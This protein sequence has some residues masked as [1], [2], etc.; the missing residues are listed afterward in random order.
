M[1]F[2]ISQ[3]IPLILALPAHRSA[4]EGHRILGLKAF[5]MLSEYK[6]LA[7]NET[8]KAFNLAMISSVLSTVR[9]FSVERDRIAGEWKA[10]EA[11][12]TRRERLLAVIRNISPLEKGNYWSRIV[13]I[14]VTVGFTIP[15]HASEIQVMI[16][17]GVAT[18]ILV[19][20]SLEIF[21]KVLEFGL[22]NLFEKRL[23]IEK[24]KKWQEQS[25]KRYKNIVGSFVD[26]A[27]GVHIRYYP[28]EGEIYGFKIK[29]PKG[30]RELKE[31]LLAMHFYF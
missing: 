21:S 4:N 27:L 20:V 16:P 18:L 24:E 7:T 31:H 13:S 23:P 6:N 26:Q 5:E 3:A 15:V 9:A 8:E 14:L 19:L 25:I 17:S 29:E 30:V 28:E 22:A 1:R 2:E 12:K 10:I 11:I